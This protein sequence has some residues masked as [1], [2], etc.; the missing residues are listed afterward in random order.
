MS[1]F[2]TL[3]EY[4]ASVK[5][6][7]SER[8]RGEAQSAFEEV[9]MS[10]LTDMVE[11]E[12]PDAMIDEQADQ[13]MSNFR[14]NLMNQGMD[15]DQYFKMMGMNAQDFRSSVRPTAEKQIKLDL[16]FEHIA[17]VEDFDITDG[18]I[19][20]EYSRLADQYGMKVE[21]VKKAITADSV[22]TGLKTEAEAE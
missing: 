15:P 13:M 20:A 5:E 10:R 4:S 3:E 21:D 6:Q 7:I 1:E 2:D 8:R 16:A 22:K 18:D 12:I 19:E 9:V 14:Y 17:K 11:C